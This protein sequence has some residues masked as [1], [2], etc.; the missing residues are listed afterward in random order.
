MPIQLSPPNLVTAPF[1]ITASDLPPSSKVQVTVHTVDQ[2]GEPW[3]SAATFTTTP[4]GS[5]DLSE[6]APL[7]G[8]DHN[9]DAGGLLWSLRP[10]PELS[11]AYFEPPTGGY[12]VTVSVTL[13]NVL[14]AQASTRRLMRRPD[15][16]ETPVREQG[17][18]GTL[19]RPSSHQPLRGACIR[20]GGSEGGLY[21]LEGALLASEGF[22]T[23]SLA[24]FGVPDTALS[25][26]LINIPLEYFQQAIVFVRAQPEVAGRRIGITGASKGGEAA[27]LIAATYPESIGAVAA[28]SPGGL[29]FEG[30][31]R[32]RTFPAGQAMSSWS[33]DGQ[34]LP[35]V[36]YRTDWNALFAGPGP[37]SM[38]PA[39]REAVAAASPQEL[40]A[41]TIPVERIDGPVLLVS[42]EQ[43]QVW[44]AT[45]LSRC[46]EERREQA[47]RPVRHLWHPR[48]GHALSLPGLPTYSS[49]PWTSMGGDD[50][51]NAQLQFTGW[52]ARLETLGTVWN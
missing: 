25:E 39:H 40:R 18:V 12:D 48:A 38:T 49:V 10:R 14:L 47:G 41:A 30:I 20:L 42:G 17:L 50:D 46:V 11:P 22:L 16:L 33:L 23:L 52:Q 32:T 7:G 45:E 3:Q 15:L 43:D 13:G 19:F 37:Y 35:Y 29:V 6:Q 26:Q 44:Q 31:D 27:L 51:A 21:D 8:S 24:Y 36:A 9:T 5:L 1:E 2:H 34:P 28:F 4:D